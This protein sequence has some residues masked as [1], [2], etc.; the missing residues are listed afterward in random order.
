VGSFG[1]NIQQRKDLKEIGCE[2][3]DEIQLVQDMVQ[4]RDIVNMTINCHIQWVRNF[5][6]TFSRKTVSWSYT[7]I[8]T[9]DHTLILKTIIARRSSQQVMPPSFDLL[10]FF[11]YGNH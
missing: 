2:D 1:I 3:V 11:C 5:V 9:K 7:E 6:T 10:I 4:L 8:H